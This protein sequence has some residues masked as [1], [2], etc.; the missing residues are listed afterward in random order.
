MSPKQAM[1]AGILL[2][3]AA[4]LTLG[5]VLGAYSSLPA[6]A[7][8]VFTPMVLSRLTP[9]TLAGRPKVNLSIPLFASPLL[10][11][12]L[13]SGSAVIV[14]TSGRGGLRKESAG[15][16]WAVRNSLTLS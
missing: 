9:C 3:C 10:R 13:F 6:N 1:L 12:I 7:A 14:L 8:Q 4:M 16:G 5:L 2:G 11:K 15:V